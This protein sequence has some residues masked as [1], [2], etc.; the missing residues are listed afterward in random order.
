MNLVFCG[1]PGA[2]KTELLKYLTEYIPKEEK[3]MTI[4]DNLEIHYRELN[5]GGELCG[6]ESRRGTFFLYEGYQD[7]APAKSAV[8]VAV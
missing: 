6:I 4:E 8:G 5:P 7:G 2:G 3:T 1:Q